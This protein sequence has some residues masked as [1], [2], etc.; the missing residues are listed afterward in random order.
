MTRPPF[1]DRE[2]AEDIAVTVMPA[3][4]ERSRIIFDATGL[5]DPL[6]ISLARDAVIVT[7]SIGAEGTISIDG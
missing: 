3:T 1:E 2:W 4:G 6:D 7:V 5:N